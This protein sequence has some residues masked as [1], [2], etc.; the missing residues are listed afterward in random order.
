MAAMGGSGS[1]WM[2]NWPPCTLVVVQRE[3]PIAQVNADSDCRT[4]YL[5]KVLIF[6]V[7]FGK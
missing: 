1:Y 6:G 4:L 7:T 2:E 3:A 5:H